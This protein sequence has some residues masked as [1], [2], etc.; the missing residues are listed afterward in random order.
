MYIDFTLDQAKLYLLMLMAKVSKEVGDGFEIVPYYNV[1]EEVKWV[2][3]KA[4]V[5]LYIKSSTDFIGSEYFNVTNN[6][7]TLDHP[8]I[9]Y[10]LNC[11]SKRNYE[12]DVQISNIS[13]YAYMAAVAIKKNMF[14]ELMPILDKMSNFLRIPP[15]DT[16][17]DSIRHYTTNLRR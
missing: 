6:M 12:I 4:Q 17:L 13:L 10:A 1:D 14:I 15:K 3:Y 9:E 2:I 8:E 11:L 5:S 7:I 16:S